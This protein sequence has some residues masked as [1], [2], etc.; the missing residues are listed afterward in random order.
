MPNGVITESMPCHN[1]QPLK[2]IKNCVLVLAFLVFSTQPAWASVQSSQRILVLGDSLSAAYGLQVEQ[3]WVNLMREELGSAATI[4]N[5]SI[6][7]E[8]SGG[9]LRALPGLLKQHQ[10]DIVII[11]LGANDGLRGF[12]I[13]VLQSNLAQMI[14]LAQAEQAKVV[15]LGMHIPPNYGPV[16]SEAFHQTFHALAREFNIPLLPFLLD[17]VA[18]KP[19]LMQDDRLHP[20]ADAQPLIK[21]NVLKVLQ[22]LLQHRG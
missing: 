6:S 15:L 9:G 21:E 2:V 18:L 1:G 3:G 11:E 13:Q 22:P 17:G 8:T 7:G 4:I 16:Y 19:E 10:P 20:T 5:A 14:S 12:P